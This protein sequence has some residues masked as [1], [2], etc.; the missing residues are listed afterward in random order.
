[1][2]VENQPLIDVTGRKLLALEPLRIVLLE[3]EKEVEDKY[4][5][6]KKLSAKDCIVPRC[7]SF[8]NLITLGVQLHYYM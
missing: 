4:E 8:S 3:N 6:Q 1:M 5:R 2:Q 7:E